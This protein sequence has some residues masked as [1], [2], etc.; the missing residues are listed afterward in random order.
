MPPVLA[1]EAIQLEAQHRRQLLQVCVSIRAVTPR[2]ADTTFS[3][4]RQGSCLLIP[5]K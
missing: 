1:R 4:T 5:D 2:R 3:R